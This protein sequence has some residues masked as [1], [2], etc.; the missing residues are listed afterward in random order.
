MNIFGIIFFLEKLNLYGDNLRF[1][2]VIISINVDE[3]YAYDLLDN[4]NMKRFH[5]K[6]FLQKKFLQQKF[7]NKKHEFISNKINNF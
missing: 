4:L 7:L 1:Y 3:G 6:T 2:L 5:C